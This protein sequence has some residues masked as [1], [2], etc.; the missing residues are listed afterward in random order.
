MATNVTSKAVEGF[1][2]EF[3]ARM[4]GHKV[5]GGVSDANLGVTTANVM[6]GVVG[7]YG[8]RFIK[9]VLCKDTKFGN[10]SLINHM[11]KGDM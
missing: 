5:A 8:M 1:G 10:F 6:C 2:A 11:K 3:V 9:R 4:R 7:Y